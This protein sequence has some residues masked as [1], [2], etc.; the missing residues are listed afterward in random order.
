MR[1]ARFLLAALALAG[2]AR[3]QP[4]DQA[5]DA[6]L[7]DSF[8]AAQAYRGAL[9]G[10]WTLTAGNQAAILDLRF[11]DHDGRLEAVWRDLRRPGA[12]DASGVV[13]QVTVTGEALTLAF[14]TRPGVRDV[15]SLRRVAGGWSGE[16]TEAE[17]TLAVRLSKTSP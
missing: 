1:A 10:G 13:D 16:L 15:L 8:D 14:S 6:R 12:L 9:D 2:A 5:Y 7:R 17:R 11:S 3:A 4:A